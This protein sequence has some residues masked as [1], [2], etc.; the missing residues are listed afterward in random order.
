MCRVTLVKQSYED[1]VFYFMAY[2]K[3]S[4]EKY[5]EPILGDLGILG[6]AMYD[7]NKLVN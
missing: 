6:I 2:F 3:Y 7:A 5:K 4:V 1:Q